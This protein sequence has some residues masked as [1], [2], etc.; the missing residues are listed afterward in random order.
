MTSFNNKFIFILLIVSLSFGLNSVQAATPY[1]GSLHQ[2]TGYSTGWGY[3]GNGFTF[4]DDCQP[5]AL[6][7][8]LSGGRTVSELANQTNSQ[9]LS[10]LGFSDHSYCINSTEFNIVKNDCQ[11]SK[12]GSFTCLA[13]EEL[14]T[15]DGIGDNEDFPALFFCENPSTGEAHMGGYGLSSVITQS[16]PAMHCPSSP[17]AQGGINS[18][19]SQQGLSVL[20]HPVSHLAGYN[21]LD[22]HS[23]HTV[24]GY[25]GIE[26]F[27]KNFDS[28]DSS[29]KNIWK[30]VLLLGNKVFAYGGTDSH[31]DVDTTNYN[32]VY[33]EGALNDTNVNQALKSGYF[34]VSN[35][36]EMY[37]EVSYG[38][39]N[40]HMG[41]TF[42]ATD[43]NVVNITVHYDLD[44][45]CALTIFKGQLTVGNEVW[46][47]NTSVSGSGSITIP[48][49][50]TDNAYFRSECVGSSGSNAY[51]A[52]TNPIWVNAVNATS[53]CS[54]TGWTSGSCS[55]G[56][57]GANERQQ[58]R[59]CTPSA[60]AA[61]SQCVPDVSCLGGSNYITV[62]ASGCS[63]TTIQ[64]AIDNSNPGDHI[65]VTDS[66]NYAENLIID[67]GDAEWLECGAGANISRNSGIGIFVK[68]PST[69]D[70][71]YIRGCTIKNFGWGIWLN[72]TTNARLENLSFIN[73]GTSIYLDDDSDTNKIINNTISI[74]QDYGINLEGITGW[75]GPSNNIISNNKI[76][77]SAVV[78]IW[79]DY[80]LNTQIL[81]TF[82]NGS[83]DSGDHGIEFNG[84]SSTS[85]SNIH[86][87][88]I[89]S[90]Y[91]GYWNRNAPGNNIQSNIFCPSNIN[92]D[93]EINGAGLTGDYNTCDLPGSWNDAG[94]TGCTYSC[95]DN[96]TTY[97]VGPLNGTTL[98][99]KDVNFTCYSEDTGSLANVTLYHNATG[100]WHSNQT[101]AVTGN[102]NTTI[103]AVNNLVNGTG[104]VWNCKTTDS[105]SRSSF[106]QSN[107]SALVNIFNT[108]PTTPN[109][110][111]CDYE[112]CLLNS[113]ISK[114]VNVSCFGSAD[115]EEDEITY[116][117]EAFYNNSWKH[118]GNH[119]NSY[120]VW[121]T[122][123]ISEQSEVALRCKAIDIG[124]S[125]TYS[126]YYSP[127]M[128]LTIAFPQVDL[129][130]L[131]VV[132]QN[133]TQRIFR[134]SINNTFTSS[135]NASW[136]INLGPVNK[137]SQS[138]ETLNTGE[139]MWVYVYY[140]YTN[141]GNYLVT[142]KSWGLNTINDTEVLNITV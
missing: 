72:H 53:S 85:N 33:L 44:H 94:T 36:G 16:S 86:N 74:S 71:I 22:F 62:C 104:F 75:P 46:G 91:A 8:H 59:T 34:T 6:E 26:I 111:W 80:G 109:T 131:S 140:N 48:N 68:N 130:N 126:S 134:F 38:G 138:S 129:K 117:I 70:D 121:N 142:A 24:S 135:I 105:G 5:R 9:G 39:N 107:W 40:Y 54:C 15:A 41:Q 103:F 108:P 81:S 1:K 92:L 100:T 42:N 133:S 97:L 23:I 57:C 14:S 84:H 3:D 132:Y 98:T 124:G 21:F 18:I 19:S 79:V 137:T 96:P 25:N 31:S 29:S 90:N 122:S 127:A 83:D 32:I 52:F 112:I 11:N 99:K 106:A 56:G 45:S 67:S 2:H 95:N 88:T 35:N 114:P 58:T 12:S 47:I 87:N 139:D 93:I 66:R 76:Y 128:N 49:T 63:Y 77:D 78:G 115:N 116:S 51:R 30:S 73:V 118:I 61:E 64:A 55:A 60:C 113:T 89:Y 65:N 4:G 82:I 7:G 69:V 101:I 119:T 20:N 110:I 27:N 10:W 50:I 37:M 136:E 123:V 102:S 125:N 141:S 28:D 17:T 120:L 13:G 43:N